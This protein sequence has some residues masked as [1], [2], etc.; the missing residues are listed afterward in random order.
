[1]Q[2]PTGRPHEIKRLRK[3]LRS[4]KPE[5]LVLYGRRRIGKTFL[6]RSVYRKNILFEFSGLHQA[7]MADQ[8]ENYILQFAQ[9]LSTKILENPPKTWLAAF[10]HL[11]QYLETKKTKAK[12]VIFFDE[13]PW[14]A[15]RRSKFLTAFEHFWNN[16]AS[17]RND[18]IVVICGSSASYMVEKIIL[19]R[20]GLH[21]RITEKMRLLPFNLNETAQFLTKRGILYNQYDILQLYMSIGGVPHYLE[22]VEKGE[23]V[24]QTIDRLCFTKDGFLVTEFNNIFASLFEHDHLHREIVTLL[25]KARKGYTR[26]EIIGTSK[27]FQSG[28]TFTKV[29]NELVES[30]FVT[31]YMPYKGTVKQSLYRLTDEYS[32][33][34]LKFIHGKKHGGQ[35]TWLNYFTKQ[36]YKSWCGFA[37]ETLCLKHINQL[38]TAL[39]IQKIYT[40]QGSW[41]QKGTDG[42]QGTQIDLLIDRADRVIN[43]CEIKFSANEF[44]ITKKYAEELQQK[45]NQFRTNTKTRKNIFLV[46][47]TT[48]GVKQN[49]Y[50][51][52][53]VQSSITA[54]VLFEPD[55]N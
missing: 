25:A 34:Y 2:K 10:K 37:F 49:S 17:R 22:Q 55:Q 16:Y 9:D 29:L 27:H 33:F 51:L 18:L 21:N 30:G 15:T 54:D 45:M 31:Q 8:L 32:Q 46:L 36:S 24:A 23:S 50:A 19:N 1:M 3:L 44:T 12:K 42:L 38:K 52:Q 48:N 6:I 40:E 43:L 20:G 4:K 28:G 26:N 35:G 41:V 11:E 7:N 47:I 53:L 39:G 13:F 14:I 5:L